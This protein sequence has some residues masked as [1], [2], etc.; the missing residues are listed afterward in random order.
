MTQA[1]VKPVPATSPSPARRW[2]R[3]LLV[4][5]IVLG[6]CDSVTTA[7]LPPA[8]LIVKYGSR[9]SK[10]MRLP[11]GARVH[12]RDRGNPSA[13]A[14][15]LLHGSNSS[16]HTWEPWVARLSS[17]F[18]VV[19]LDLPGHGLTGPVPGDDYSPEGMASFV[20]AFR[21]QLGLQHFY[22]AGNSMGGHIAWR[23]TLAHAKVVDKLVLVDA[24]GLNQLL[25]PDAQP[26]IPLGMRITRTP[27]L[28][29]LV[30]FVTPRHTVEQSLRATFVDQSKVTPQMIDRYYELLLFPGNR[31]TVTLRASAPVDLST[32]DRLPQIKAPTLILSGQSDTLVPV[33]AARIFH[34]RIAGS[35]LIEYP[36]VGHIPMEEIPER[37][38]SDVRQFLSSAP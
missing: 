19:T 17:S 36:K 18:R 10:F 7:D 23:Y 21:T 1:S 14:L 9:P 38:A 4:L 31:Q 20:D 33:Q 35:R 3:W 37:S 2:G 32:A 27:V 30:R 13:P 11:S 15:L 28:N 8:M 24:S 16:L 6:V 26:K 5:V 29:Q 25:P 22:L 12:Y 34:E